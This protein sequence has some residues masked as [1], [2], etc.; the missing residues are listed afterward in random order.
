M[1]FKNN[2]LPIF[3]TQVIINK[4]NDDVIK[5][6]SEI[7][8]EY[9]QTSYIFYGKIRKNKFLFTPTSISRKNQSEITFCGHVQPITAQKTQ[10]NIKGRYTILAYIAYFI[11]MLLF[12]LLAINESIFLSLISIVIYIYTIVKIENKSLLIV[13][14]LRTALSSDIVKNE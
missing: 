2:L 4:G 6:L 11:L 14:E 13:N 8:S 12:I 10:L 1:K 9:N 3:N 5:S 7:I